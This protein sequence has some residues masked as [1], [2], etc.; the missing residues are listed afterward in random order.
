MVATN[1]PSPRQTT[2]GHSEPERSEFGFDDPSTLN[3]W[4]RAAA[5]RRRDPS[6]AEIAARCA[7]IR[8][9][10][11]E[12]EHRIRAGLAPIGACERQLMRTHLKEFGTP[13]SWTAPVCRC[14][15]AGTVR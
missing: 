6:P 4:E 14:G 7:E 10:W 8:Q 11:S 12:A 5:R 1:A 13:R 15:P 2:P 3:V 9:G